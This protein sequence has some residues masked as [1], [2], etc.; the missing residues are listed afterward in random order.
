V[1]SDNHNQGLTGL[2]GGKHYFSPFFLLLQLLV[3]LAHDLLLLAVFD[4]LQVLAHFLLLDEDLQ[5]LVEL[6]RLRCDL[7]RGFNVNFKSKRF[8]RLP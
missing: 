3:D 5:L 2:A 6:L 4:H 8:G 7:G 1:L